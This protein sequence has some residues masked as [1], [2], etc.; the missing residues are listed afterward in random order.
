[1]WLKRRR[2][3]QKKIEIRRKGVKGSHYNSS[4][5]SYGAVNSLMYLSGESHSSHSSHSYDS[6]CHS[7]SHSHSFDSGSS[8]FDCGSF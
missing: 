4:A 6:G 1:M 5:N 3:N 8:G 7:S 2:F